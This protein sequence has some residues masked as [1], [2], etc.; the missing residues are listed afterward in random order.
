[1]GLDATVRSAVSTAK[2]VLGDLLVTV[3]LESFSSRD[4]DGTPTYATGVDY[5][6][7]VERKDTK[8][9]WR[10]GNEHVPSHLITFLENVV[11]TMADRITLPD[12]TQPAILEITGVEDP[13]GGQ[14]YTQV[15]CGRP[16]RGVTVT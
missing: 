12:G 14:Y 11:V 9:A 10:I 8:L 7:F 2:S 5:Q 16:E 4:G 1:M 3:T 6:A 13:N 15:I